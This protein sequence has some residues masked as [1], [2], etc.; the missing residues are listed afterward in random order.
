MFHNLI[1]EINLIGER[2]LQCIQV[3]GSNG[4]KGSSAKT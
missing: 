4:N 3:M 2:P 1:K